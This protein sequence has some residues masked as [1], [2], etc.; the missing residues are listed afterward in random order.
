MLNKW[1]TLKKAL[2]IVKEKLIYY[3]KKLSI[4]NILIILAIKLNN[5]L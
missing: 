5:K 1:L 4:L 3:S 2:S